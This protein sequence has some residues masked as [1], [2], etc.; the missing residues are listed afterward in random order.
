MTA[1]NRMHIRNRINS[2]NT[3]I[4]AMHMRVCNC[5][6]AI[7]SMQLEDDANYTTTVINDFV[8]VHHAH[9]HKHRIET[10]IGIFTIM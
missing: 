2:P 9:I 5:R 6:N 1:R 3:V 4:H 10:S 7:T 8:I